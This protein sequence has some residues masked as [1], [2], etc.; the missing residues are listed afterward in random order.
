MDGPLEQYHRYLRVFDPL[1]SA[2]NWGEPTQRRK[3]K[4]WCA[5][6]EEAEYFS[7]TVVFSLYGVD[8][9][10]DIMN[11]PHIIIVHRE[12]DVHNE[13]TAGK[14]NAYTFLKMLAAS[15]Q[16]CA[17]YGV[18][19]FALD[20]RSGSWKTHQDISYWRM[21]I[22]AEQFIKLFKHK[23]TDGRRKLSTSE[24]FTRYE[25]QKTVAS[26]KEKV[27]IANERKKLFGNVQCT[28]GFSKD[29]HRTV[30]ETS[31]QISRDMQRTGRNMSRTA[32][33]ENSIG[34]IGKKDV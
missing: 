34:S 24:W 3:F 22:D 13:T 1:N 16:F 8:F 15:V 14:W 27:W 18:W 25:K 30:C 10:I 28:D 19:N 17:E 32:R 23:L 26:N 2:P 31:G 9:I 5:R 29:M 4:K 11:R 20:I 21:V 6:C 12:H 7:G 33:P